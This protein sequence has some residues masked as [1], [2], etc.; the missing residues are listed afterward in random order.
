MPAFAPNVFELELAT[1][2]LA[3]TLPDVHVNPYQSQAGVQT[4]PMPGVTSFESQVLR[5]TSRHLR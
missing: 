2:W 5:D 4:V 3:V 1:V